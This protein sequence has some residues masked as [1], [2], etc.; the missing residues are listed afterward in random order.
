MQSPKVAICYWGLTR[1]TRLVY[2]THRF[3]LYDRL[4]AE[5]FDYDIFVHTWRTASPRT[6]NHPDPP[7]DEA[8][9][10]LLGPTKLQID[11]Q[12]EWLK[13][14]KFSNYFYQNVWDTYGDNRAQGEW[15]PELLQNHLCALE[16]LRRVYGLV[17]EPYDFFIFVRPDMEILAPFPAEKLASLGPKEILLTDSA[18]NEG[19]NDRF[20]VM[21]GTVAAPY[22]RRIEGLE[23]F[24]KMRGRIVSEKVVKA[25]IDANYDLVSMIPFS[26]RRVRADGKR[27]E[28]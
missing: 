7:I 26:M 3:Q 11:D 19:Y 4:K 20:A 5:G 9:G 17:S 12:D 23:E 16:S 6:W 8:E 1:S 27:E 15:R 21:R 28:S 24:R 10:N 25:C 13:T 2:Q 18:H 14:V 22:A